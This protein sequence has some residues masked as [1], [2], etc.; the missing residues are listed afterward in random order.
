MEYSYKE[1]L[2]DAKSSGLTSEKTMWKSIDSLD[3]ML[4]VLKEEHPDMFWDFMRK[5]HEAFYGPHFD[6][7]FALW[8]VEQM[9]HKTAE[10]KEYKGEHWSVE[11]AEKVF[12]KHKSKLPAST[13]VFDV[14][15]A[16]NA[17]YHDRCELF[18]EWDKEDYE[19]MVIEDAIKFYFMDCDWKSDGKVWEYM[20]ANK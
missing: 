14:F 19:N 13:T 10:G 3:E 18:K 16:L 9:Y 20:N 5:Q 6:E 1:M 17:N 15:V 2:M 12:T 7:K 8:Q 4:C 11:D